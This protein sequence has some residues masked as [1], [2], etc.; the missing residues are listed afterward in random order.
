MGAQTSASDLDKDVIH[1]QDEEESEESEKNEETVKIRQLTGP[2]ADSPDEGYVGDC[3]ESSDI[4]QKD[5]NNKTLEDI[6]QTE[7][8]VVL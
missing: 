1:E 4:W 2:L 7:D 5:Y 8:V 3:Q 6:L